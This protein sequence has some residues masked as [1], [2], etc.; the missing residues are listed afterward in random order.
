MSID[1]KE[2]E[3]QVL[4]GL[5]DF[6]LATVGRV[7]ELFT[8]GYTRVLV[9]D[10]VGLGKTLIAKGTLARMVAYKREH[11]K[12]PLFKA[13]YICSNQSIARQ[14]LMKLKLDEK[15]KVDEI[16]DTRLS[17]QHLKIFEN[18]HDNELRKQY[19]QLIPLTPQTSFQLTRNGCGTDRERALIYAILKRYK[20]LRN[21]Q[22]ELE[23]FL[24]YRATTGWNSWVRDEYEKRVVAC[25]KA[26]KGEYL[27]VMKDKVATYFEGEKTLLEQVRQECRRIRQGKADTLEGRSKIINRLRQMMAQISVDLMTPDLVIMDEFQ[28]FPELLSTQEQ[29][30][31]TILARKFLST[32]EEKD[33]KVRTLLLSATPYKLYSTLEEINRDE[34]DTH[35][36]E[37]FRVMDFLFEENKVASQEFKDVWKDYSF[38]LAQ[39]T[40]DNVAMIYSKKQIAEEYLY[41]GMCRTERMLIKGADKLIES[42]KEILKVTTEDI[43]SYSDASMLLE[44]IGL[45]EKVPIEYIK[46][47]PYMLSFMENYKFKKDIEKYFKQQ[48]ENIK[49]ANLSRLWLKKHVISE[50][51]E[52]KGNNARFTMLKEMALAQNAAQLLWV[53]PS[54]PYYAFEGCYK[55]SEHFS[56]LLV[57]SKW[58]M[59]PRA[60]A[61]LLSYEAERCTIGKMIKRLAKRGKEDRSYF[62]K[63]RYPY[64]ALKYRTEKEEEVSMT[65]FSLLY[66]SATLMKLFEPVEVV[67][68]K[69]S[70][71]ELQEEL[72]QKIE[73]LLTQIQYISNGE[74]DKADDR[75]YYMAPL[76]FDEQEEAV[77]EWF[78][79]P[80]GDIRVEGY[81]E[82]DEEDKADGE[83]IQVEEGAYSKYFKCLTYYADHKHEMPLGKMPDDLAD[84][85]V[86]MI[87]GSPAICSL[88]MLGINSSE[89][90]PCAVRL[91]KTLVS[92]FN[93]PEATAI[94]K[95]AYRQQ[96]RKRPWEAVLKYAMDGNI[97]A[98]LDEYIYLLK[99]A[100]GITTAPTAIQNQGLVD[101]MIHALRT[102]TANYSVDTYDIFKNRITG[103]KKAEPMKMR[104]HFAVGFYD[105]STQDKKVQRKESIRLSF[106]SPFRPFVLATTSIGQE[107]LDFH[108]YCRKVMHW[109]LPGNP[110]DIEQR[111]GRINRY[112]CL[113]I[114][115]NVAQIYG[116]LAFKNNIW[117]EMFE[118]ASQERRE[119]D[120]ELVPYWCM[121]QHGEIKIQ[122][123]VPMYPYSKD[124]AKYERLIKVLSLYRIS[125]GQARQEELLE[126]LFKTEIDEKEL[127]KLFMNLSPFYKDKKAI[128]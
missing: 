16:S 20:S 69:L 43:L 39:V 46:S 48:P 80:D 122:R 78:Q 58:E 27:R 8:S 24:R 123:I 1:F 71:K 106:N 6:Q 99:E 81:V 125:L 22:E 73:E 114:R 25:D 94:I 36:K 82:K 108:Y 118:A 92:R 91:A 83:D 60:I 112:K 17:M 75:W 86:Y 53:P 42:D 97:Q 54:R 30:E 57:F 40:A 87:L 14:N 2:R 110:I 15:M 50:Y 63:T 70:L 62:A 115:Q 107:G 18:E 104:S 11:S 49:L 88:R 79:N 59:V 126:Y 103:N 113:A 41:K 32:A 116:E 77:S 117:D 85:L 47:A 64:P 10:E 38:L 5:K 89:A 7:T 26:S 74:N 105:T 96:G 102:N 52:I 12:E 29:N 90:I 13:V 65:A 109:N 95:L 4:S 111:E 120:C 34:G 124:I 44:K 66:P 35:Y 127:E 68:R 100:E 9:A 98:M 37:F 56:K 76:F 55:G 3:K 128:E 28:R 72:K 84:V 121:P 21:Y 67:K 101:Y 93:T 51:N 19:I 61:A 31:A 33:N 119:E 45:N 23:E